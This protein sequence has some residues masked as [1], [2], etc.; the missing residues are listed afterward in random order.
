MG[1]VAKTADAAQPPVIAN[2]QLQLL[3]KIVARVMLLPFEGRVEVYP[4]GCFLDP[5]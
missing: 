1:R 2:G 4:E 5:R 3:C